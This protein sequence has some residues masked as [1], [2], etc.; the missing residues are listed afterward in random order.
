MS[1]G[2]WAS[3]GKVLPGPWGN[4]SYQP[5]GRGSHGTVIVKEN[6]ILWGGELGTGVPKVHD[7]PEKREFLSRV[8]ILHLASGGWECRTSH[9][10][11]PLAISSYACFAIDTNVYYFGGFCGHSDCFH[12]SIH[13]LSIPS[14]QWTELAPTTSD[15]DTPMKKSA[16]GMVAFKELDEDIL[17]V[18]GGWGSVVAAGRQKGPW[19]YETKSNLPATNEQHM[20]SLSTSKC[21]LILLCTSSVVAAGEWSS[22]SVTGQIPPPCAMFS[23]TYI[24]SNRAVMF[25]CRDSQLTCDLWLVDL[26]KN[27]VV[28]EPYINYSSHTHVTCHTALEQDS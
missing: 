10:T 6:L 17:F 1:G 18:V 4:Q 20:F 19:R 3:L 12:N 16:C 26:T 2:I 7:S 9:G 21:L 15:E 24:D 23:L 25:G 8:E 14:L 5:V 13:Q 22:P 11:P 27:H 28:S